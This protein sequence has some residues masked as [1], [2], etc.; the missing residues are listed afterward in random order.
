MVA[1][2]CCVDFCCSAAGSIVLLLPLS[3]P[4]FLSL[5]FCLSLSLCIDSFLFT[6][7]WRSETLPDSFV[8]K[9]KNNKKMTLAPEL[10]SHSSHQASPVLCCTPPRTFFFPGHLHSFVNIFMMTF[11]KFLF[12][13]MFSPLADLYLEVQ[14]PQFSAGPPC[15]CCPLFRHAEREKDDGEASD[16]LTCLQ[17]WWA[18]C[19]LCRRAS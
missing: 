16:R 7:L 8:V 17:W 10:P 19:F 4:R 6:M 11:L 14:F 12:S 9:K 3:F 15:G 2:V 13:Y 5:S 18:L 1:T